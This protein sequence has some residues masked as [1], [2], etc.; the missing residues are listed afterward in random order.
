MILI[1]LLVFES[2]AKTEE[3]SYTH[4]D[5][6]NTEFVERIEDCINKYK[7]EC[8]FLMLNDV[9]NISQELE[10]YTGAKHALRFPL[11]WFIPVMLNAQKALDENAANTPMTQEKIDIAAKKFMGMIA[12]DFEKNDPKLVFVV[13]VPNPANHEKM[14]DAYSYTLEKAPELFT[15]IWDRYELE[16][17]K[18]I[19]RID[20]MYKKMPDEELVLYNIYKKKESIDN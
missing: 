8:T 10:I 9:I 2:Y 16:S 19:D 7:D 3:R 14:F 1:F 20:Y 12:Q 11:P 5:Y 6:E 13:H 4:K 17:S 18:M 15:P